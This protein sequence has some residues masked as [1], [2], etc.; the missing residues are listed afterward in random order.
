MK[1]IIDFVAKYPVAITALICIVFHFL[2]PFK[3][4]PFGDGEYHEGTIQ[5]VEYILNGFQ[6]NIRVDK[7]MFTLFYYLTPYSLAYAFHSD[8]VFYLFGIAFNSIVV[9]AGIFYL[10]KT[11]DLLGFSNKVKACALIILCLFPIH[12]YY[13]MGILAE[14]AA[15]FAITLFV[16]SWVRI[17]EKSGSRRHFVALSFA[18]LML[19][20]TRPNLLPF[21]IV[22]LLYFLVLK[23]D[24]NRK[25]AVI[26]LVVIPLF[27]LGFFEGKVSRVDEN[28]KSIVFRNQILWSRFE[29]RDEPFNWLP[30]HGQ[31]QFASSDYLNNLKK[32][33]EL[34]SICDQNNFDKTQYYLNWVKDDIIQNPGLTLRQYFLKFFQ[35]QSF[36]ISPLMKSN[37]S[38]LIKY[39][40]HGYINL[41]NYVLILFALIGMYLLAKNRKYRLFFPSLFLWGWSLLY[42]FIFHSEQRYMFPVRPLLIF[43]FAYTINHYFQDKKSSS[44]QAH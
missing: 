9:C 14:T 20:G 7:G 1:R 23:F 41:I 34:D 29:L 2:L 28:F 31:D 17:N 40:V 44:S 25:I 4:K 35:S 8:A 24:W 43:L 21:L 5:L 22:F 13:A 32:R 6:G 27:L 12:V 36:I 3:P 11:L 38:N 18:L 16:Y 42:V 30:Q 19:V 39:G 10:F 37:K 15:F 33:A 26:A